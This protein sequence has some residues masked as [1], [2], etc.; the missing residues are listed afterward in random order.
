MIT[1]LE[2]ITNEHNL[3]LVGLA[4]TVCLIACF[5]SI[6]LFF[7]AWVAEGRPKFYW[8]LGTGLVAGAGIWATHFIAMLAYQ[9]AL[10][11]AYDVPLTVLSVFISVSLCTL[12]AGIALYMNRLTL[13]GLTVGAAIGFMHFTGM[14]AL[15]LSGHIE[16]DGAYVAASWIIGLAV[17]ALAFNLIRILDGVSRHLV[18]TALFTLAICGLHFTG[19]TAVTLVPDPAMPFSYATVDPKWLAVFT[20]MLSAMILSTAF[21]MAVFDKHLAGRNAQEAERMRR[22]AEELE[23][24]RDELEAVRDNLLSALEAAAAGSQ[25]KSQF[26]AAIS[27]ELRTPLNAI[28]GFSE[29]M[30]HEHFGPLPNDHYREYTGHIHESGRHLLALINDILDFS[31]LDAGRLELEEAP[32]EV[33]MAIDAAH[34]MISHLAESGEISVHVSETAHLPLIDGDE[35]RVRQILLNILSNAV[36]FTPKGGSVAISAQLR[37]TGELSIDIRDTGIGIARKDIALAMENFGQIDN[38]LHRQYEGTGLGL[39]LSR[40]LMELHGGRLELESEVGV[41]TCV[42]LVFPAGRVLAATIQ[43]GMQTG[44]QAATQ[45]GTAQKERKVTLI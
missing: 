14:S 18:G 6:D 3:W 27:H 39:P 26:L 25:A 34:R 43:A 4:A 8:L 16:W 42:S 40:R 29:M 19:M 17:M 44:T 7:R 1:V 12:G 23:I 21:L 28:I 11:V 5:T 36:K 32:L 45:T 2:C 22:Y 20:A 30:A 35:R 24:T 38:S 33:G 41:G 15:R 37:D 13:G 31:K 10:P 9:S